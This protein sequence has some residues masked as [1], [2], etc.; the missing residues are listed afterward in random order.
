VLSTAN[1]LTALFNLVLPSPTSE[2]ITLLVQ[3]HRLGM[4][5]RSDRRIEGTGTKPS[6]RQTQWYARIPPRTHGSKVIARRSWNH[7]RTSASDSGSFGSKD[8]VSNF[9]KGS[10]R[11]FQPYILLGF[12]HLLFFVII[13]FLKLK[14]IFRKGWNRF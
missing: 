12:E 4:N 13:L 1:R 3:N 11:G 2:R 7:L 9:E 14:S 10:T 5:R 6:T 8:G